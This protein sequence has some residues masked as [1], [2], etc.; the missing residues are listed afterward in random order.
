[1]NLLIALTFILGYAA[2]AF[3]QR[4]KINKSAVALLTGVICWTIYIVA[5]PDKN[6]VTDQLYHH[7][8]QIGSI[9][10]FIL[11]AMTIVEIIDA[12]DGFQVINQKIKTRDKRKLLW[13]IAILSFFLSAV[14]DNLTTAIVMV[15]L[16]RKLIG[17]QQL[18]LLYVGIV[19]IAA[20]AGGAWSPVGD[21][22]TT[23]LWIGG[24]IS[25]VNIILEL[26]V[27]SL[28]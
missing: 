14:I 24:Q 1:M 3:E 2:I 22:T 11:S 26:F 12:H 7:F 4:L 13:I 27:P 19:I 21:V 17:D 25:A 28:V 16:L 8:G 9:L 6:L 23:M 10:F 20:N 15:S 18:R 5:T